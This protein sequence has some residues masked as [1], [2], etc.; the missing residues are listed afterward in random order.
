MNLLRCY[1]PDYITAS[2]SPCSP[3]LSGTVFI[4]SVRQCDT[5]LLLI[6]CVIG[7]NNNSNNSSTTT[8]AII[9]L[10]LQNDYK[11]IN[12]VYGCWLICCH[13]TLGL[14]HQ[15]VTTDD[16][17]LYFSFLSDWEDLDD[18]SGSSWDHWEGLLCHSMSSHLHKLQQRDTFKYL[19]IISSLLYPPL[20]FYPHSRLCFRSG[21]YIAAVS[22]GMTAVL[23]M[24]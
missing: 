8:L 16:N 18:C 12:S 1:K 15:K 24:F 23:F 22:F 2:L 19:F 9:G 11:D 13:Y 7:Y 3:P 20:L 4:L 10:F 17:S 21:D 14:D 6:C 5:G